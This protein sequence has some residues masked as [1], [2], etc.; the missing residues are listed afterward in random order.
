MKQTGDRDK[1]TGK[2]EGGRGE[3]D[4]GGGRT[5]GRTSRRVSDERARWPRGAGLRSAVGESAD[6]HFAKEPLSRP[7]LRPVE[8]ALGARAACGGAPASSCGGSGCGC[9]RFLMSEFSARAQSQPRAAVGSRAGRRRCRR[10]RRCT[11]S[12]PARSGWAC[13]RR[14]AAT[15]RHH[16]GS[17]RELARRPPTPAP[18]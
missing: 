5:D 13:A 14:P 15:R 9:A 12:R 10:C 18:T 8:R 6:Q 11:H 1:P 4:E 2:S 16:E 7:A 3:E 17:A